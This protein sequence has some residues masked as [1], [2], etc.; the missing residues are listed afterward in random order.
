MAVTPQELTMLSSAIMKVELLQN[1]MKDENV[2]NSLRD[3]KDHLMRAWTKA[4]L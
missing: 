4:H 2:K 3:A 1:R